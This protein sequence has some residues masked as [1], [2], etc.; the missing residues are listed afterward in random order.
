MHPLVYLTGTP[1]SGKT[2]LCLALAAAMPALQVL[3]YSE[4]LADHLAKKHA[5]SVAHEELRRSS[6]AIITQEDVELVDEHLLQLS[7]ELRARAPVIVASHPATRE[8]YGFRA[9][10]FSAA[11]L[12]R[13]RPTAVCMLIATA[14]EVNARV[15]ASPEGRPL[16]GEKQ[17]QTHIDIQIAIATTYAFS[18]AVPLYFIESG[19]NTGAAAEKLL[20][21]LRK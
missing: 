5:R 20:G 2:T 8:S 12:Q 6:S 17:T 21:L 3:E 16:D 11:Q 9:V 1:A 13:L 4:L 18:A 19:S 14:E 15:R 10:M 7:A